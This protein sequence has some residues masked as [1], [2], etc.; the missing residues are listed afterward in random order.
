MTLSLTTLEAG[1]QI[2]VDLT[3][4]TFLIVPAVLILPEAD[5]AESEEEGPE[6]F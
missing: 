2:G 1:A 4:N 5:P 3:P 6:I